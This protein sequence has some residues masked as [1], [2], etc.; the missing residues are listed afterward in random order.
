MKSYKLEMVRERA[1]HQE[2]D[3]VESLAGSRY[4]HRRASA[5]HAQRVV[6]TELN[7]FRKM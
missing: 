7:S 2:L 1:V 5:I 6:T 4:A 3:W